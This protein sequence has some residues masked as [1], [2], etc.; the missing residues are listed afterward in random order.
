M[1]TL[2]YKPVVGN[3]WANAANWF[4]NSAA[5]I[6]AGTILPATAPWLANNVFKNYDLAFATGVTVS[7]R[8]GETA[9]SYE[10]GNGFTIT[11][12]CSIPVIFGYDAGEDFGQI[13]VYGGNYSAAVTGYLFIIYGGTFQSTVTSSAGTNIIDGTFQGEV[14]TVAGGALVIGGGVFQSTVTLAGDNVSIQAGTF[15]GAVTINRTSGLAVSGGTFNSGFTQTAG[16][17]TGGTFN[18]TYTR[19]AG[20]VTG[21][22]FNN[23]IINQFYRNGFPPPL[24]FNGYNPKALDVLGT[25]LV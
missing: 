5:T 3:D 17:V 1:P 11:G 9:G 6:S 4:T 18:G 20:N 16:N 25:G 21:G 8:T 14:N 10:I 19:V 23:G 2:Y 7:P 12:T 24:V 22:T 15:N 13:A